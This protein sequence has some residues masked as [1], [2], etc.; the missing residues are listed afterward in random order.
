[1]THDDV[2]AQTPHG[3]PLTMTGKR[4]HQHSRSN[5]GSA[6]WLELKDDKNVCHGVHVCY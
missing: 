1:M 6:V 5:C 4:C 2:H 3:R